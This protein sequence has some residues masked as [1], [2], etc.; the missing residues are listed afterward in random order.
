MVGSSGV[1]PALLTTRSV[2]ALLGGNSQAEMITGSSPVIPRVLVELKV[3]IRGQQAV[4]DR[5]EDGH[6]PLHGLSSH[7]HALLIH[8]AKDIPTTGLK[9][10]GLSV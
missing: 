10:S 3:L 8:Q 9:S 1:R 5:V 2:L 6:G 7:R 4:K